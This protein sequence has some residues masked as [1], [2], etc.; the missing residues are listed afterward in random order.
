MP[1][2]ESIQH[3]IE[4]VADSKAKTILTALVSRIDRLES[5]NEDLVIR[6]DQLESIIEELVIRVDQL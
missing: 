6:V 2:S 4:A 1:P 5:I 3:Y